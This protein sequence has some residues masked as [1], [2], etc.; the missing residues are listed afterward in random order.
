[1]TVRLSTTLNNVGSMSNDENKEIIL[2]F[3]DFMKRIGTSER[4]QNNNL[5]AIISYSK[6]L[7]PSVSM[8]NVKNKDQITAFLDSKIKGLF[9]NP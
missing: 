8:D 3:F 2:Q 5:N 7:G 9:S 6:F 1:V 4:Y